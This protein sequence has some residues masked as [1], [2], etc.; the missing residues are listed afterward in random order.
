M[1]RLYITSETTDGLEE[2][3]EDRVTEE[4][5]DHAGYK[6]L[7]MDYEVDSGEHHLYLDLQ[8]GPKATGSR[9]KAPEFHV[10][11]ADTQEDLSEMVD[12][13]EEPEHRPRKMR[14][15]NV[16]LSSYAV[17]NG[18]HYQACIIEKGPWL[19]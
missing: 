17:D 14:N 4:T 10:L 3:F 13:L 2:T 1:G 5:R 7:D 12:E 8:K 9:G 15:R 6:L 11:E 16:G 18:T 19:S